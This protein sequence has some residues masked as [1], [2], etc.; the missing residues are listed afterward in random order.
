MTEKEYRVK[1]AY[2]GCY[3]VQHRKAFLGLSFWWTLGIARDTE[4]IKALVEHHRTR[5]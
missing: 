4:E 2:D 1:S 5:L 3:Y